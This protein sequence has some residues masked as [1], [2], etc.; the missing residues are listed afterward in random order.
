MNKNAIDK[1][2]RLTITTWVDTALC[3]WIIPARSS[4]TRIWRTRYRCKPWWTIDEMNISEFS[5][6]STVNLHI[7]DEKHRSAS[8]TYVEATLGTCITDTLSIFT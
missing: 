2:V 8:A 4:F 1:E 6:I 5:V 7:V 3:P